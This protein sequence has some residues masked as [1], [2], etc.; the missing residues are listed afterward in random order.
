MAD[1]GEKIKKLRFERKWSQDKL[2]ERVG[3]GRQ[4]ISR[5]ENGRILPNA[6]KSPKASRGSRRLGRLPPEQR[7]EEP[8]RHWDRGQD[9]SQPVRRSGK[10]GRKRPDDDPESL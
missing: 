1:L 3:V 7:G 8:G 4:Y 9:S 2:A 5:Y 10:D 6:E